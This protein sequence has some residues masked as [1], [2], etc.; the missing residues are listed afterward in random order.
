MNAAVVFEIRNRLLSNSMFYCLTL[1]SEN[2]CPTIWWVIRRSTNW[3]AWLEEGWLAVWKQ[4]QEIGLSVGNEMCPLTATSLPPV[5]CQLWEQRPRMIRSRQTAS[6]VWNGCWQRQDAGCCSRWSQGLI[7]YPAS[8]STT[9]ALW[10]GR[11][12][13]VCP[14]S[15]LVVCHSRLVA[16][17][18]ILV[19]WFRSWHF[20][21]PPSSASD[22]LRVDDVTAINAVMT[23]SASNSSATCLQI[24]K[25]VSKLEYGWRSLIRQKLPPQ[26]KQLDYWGW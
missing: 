24:L 6:W 12:T 8:S 18:R 16:M 14:L 5:D 1:I 23:S 9:W 19:R 11:A 7:C 22:A 4:R 26:W 10:V 13:A 25:K 21:R 20:R 2:N 15:I 17:T 3:T